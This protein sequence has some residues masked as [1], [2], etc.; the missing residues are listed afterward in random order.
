[1]S[2]IMAIILFNLAVAG[3]YGD[4]SSPLALENETMEPPVAGFGEDGSTPAGAAAVYQVTVL[5]TWEIPSGTQVLG[6]DYIDNMYGHNVVAYVS[7][8]DNKIYFMDAVTGAAVTP[9]LDI[10]G[11]NTNPYGCAYVSQTG[12]ARLH[13]NDYVNPL[14][15]YKTVMGWDTYDNM[16]S[17]TCAG[18][19]Y[20]AGENKIFE[21]WTDGDPGNY[22]CYVAIFSPYSSFGSHYE[23]DCATTQDWWATGM[24]LFPQSGGGTGIA[25]TMSESAWI[26]FFNYPG[27]PGAVYY[28]YGV[29]PYVETMQLSFDLTYSEELG[30]FFHAWFDGTDYFISKLDIEEVS[31]RQTT[32][33]EIKSAF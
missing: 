11:S 3:N 25:V 30:V 31:L 6:M 10:A 4:I 17:N 16:V 9:S 14:I 19:D 28:G 32:W 7:H 12:D 20:K 5:N 22:T 24:T 26:R 29:L 8:Y 27:S 1:M 33:A 13:V 21:I 2:G 23:L 15:F 18:M